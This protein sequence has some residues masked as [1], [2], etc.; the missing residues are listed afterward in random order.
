VNR[1]P[2]THDDADGVYL[3]PRHHYLGIASNAVHEYAHNDVGP[4]TPINEAAHDFMFA[5]DDAL[6]EW[7]LLARYVGRRVPPECSAS[8]A[9]VRAAALRLVAAGIAF[10][11]VD[12]LDRGEE[13]V[14]R[15]SLQCDARGRF[16]DDMDI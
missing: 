10:L 3:V 15:E 16:V 7:S 14:K 12:A 6:A 11:T 4:G 5:V 8:R 13:T 2:L 1:E 9:E